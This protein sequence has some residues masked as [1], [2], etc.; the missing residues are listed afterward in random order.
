MKPLTPIALLALLACTDKGGPSGDDSRAGDDTRVTGDSVDDSGADDSGQVVIPNLLRSRHS[1][2]AAE[3]VEMTATS[4]AGV[5]DTS[6]LYASNLGDTCGVGWQPQGSL[7]DEAPSRDSQDRS[8]KSVPDSGATWY[9][10]DGDGQRSIGILVVDACATG[11]CSDITF[12]AGRV[13]QM[14]S[15]GKTTHL[16]LSTHPDTGA[17]AP[18]WDDAGWQAVVDETFISAGRE[19]DV[20][21][22]AGPT[23]L[24]TGE[25]TTRYLKVEVRNDGA[26]GDDFYT[27]LRALKLF[28]L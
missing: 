23:A 5:E 1:G 11:D 24:E 15:D 28:E 2:G 18:A 16:R 13:F 14:Y 26:H 4:A 7:C 10:Y 8:S 17:A 3:V 21:T 20:F 25:Q 22:V 19:I 12:N 9:A 27:E 6:L